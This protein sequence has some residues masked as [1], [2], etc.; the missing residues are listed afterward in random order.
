MFSKIKGRGFER[1]TVGAKL[2]EFRWLQR[3]FDECK[4]HNVWSETAF[5]FRKILYFYRKEMHIPILKG[6]DDQDD[7]SFVKEHFLYVLI[8]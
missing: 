6:E 7:Q 4:T 3:A 1:K 2:I 8:T 5:I